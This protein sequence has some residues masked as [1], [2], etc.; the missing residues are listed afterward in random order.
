MNRKGR[1]DNPVLVMVPGDNDELPL[2]GAAGSS[3]SAGEVKSLR[4]SSA[5]STLLSDIWRG[6]PIGGSGSGIGIGCGGGSCGHGG[7]NGGDNNDGGGGGNNGR[8]G[9]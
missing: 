6:C 3:A 2:D 5:G 8:G 9:S 4:D 7:D 1:K